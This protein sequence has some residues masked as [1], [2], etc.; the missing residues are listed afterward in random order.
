MYCYHT[1]GNWNQF[2]RSWDRASWYI[3]IVKPTRC[4]IFRVYWISIYMFRMVFPPIISS[5]RLYI[6]RQ[7]Y[8]IQV[9][10]LLASR[11]EMGSISF[12]LASSQR[13]CMTYTWR[14]MYSLELLM[15]DGKTSETCRVIFNEL[16]EFCIWL[17]LLWNCNTMHDPMNVRQH[18]V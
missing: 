4:T 16:E 18:L 10:W 7:V 3:S 13:N 5:C 9:S 8:V 11:H 12:P 2:W 6:Q 17:V 15:M 1:S 14:C